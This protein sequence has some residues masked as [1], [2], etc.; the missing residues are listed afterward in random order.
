MKNI[1]DILK[2]KTNDIQPGRGKI[3][4]SEPFLLDYFF[5]RSVV[6]LAEH[7]E[8]GSFGVIINKPVTARFND[9]VKNFPDFDSK[10]YLGGPVQSDSLFFI[11]TLGDKIPE[12]IEIIEDIYWGGDIEQIREMILLKELNP[13]DI[14]FFVGYSGWSPKQLDEE[15]QRNSWVVSNITADQFLKT[16]PS[17]L[18]D[19]SLHL[20]GGEYKYWTSFPDDPGLN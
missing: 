1:D 18:W 10:L 7:N 5:K 2:I 15:L 14:R 3:L 8:E 11:H 13:D 20:L 9:V 12:S 4:I 19:R 17:S 16:N 6:L